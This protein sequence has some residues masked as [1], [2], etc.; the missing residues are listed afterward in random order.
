MTQS[1]SGTGANVQHNVGGGG[2]QES[3]FQRISRAAVFRGVAHEVKERDEGSSGK[4][5]RSEREKREREREREKR[6]PEVEWCSI[7][8]LELE[9][10]ASRKGR[11]ADAQPRKFLR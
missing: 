5:M 1:G 9:I 3:V 10:E 6:V 2:S 4:A 7:H 11:G 8:P